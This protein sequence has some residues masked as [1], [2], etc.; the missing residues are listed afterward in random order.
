[1]GN[2]GIIVGDSNQ[3]EIKIEGGSVPLF[4]DNTGLGLFFEVSDLNAPGGQTGYS[5]IN[6]IVS[7]SLGGPNAPSLIPDED[8]Y[9][10]LGINTSRW[11]NVYANFFVGVAT[12]AQY[13]D[14]AE[15]YL[16]DKE[17]SPGTVLE[18]GGSAEV[19]L[20]QDETRRVAGIVSSNPAYLMNSDLK[21]DY[22]V[23]LALQGRVPCKV[24][25]KISKGDMLVSG[26]NGYA[27]P[28][29]DPKIGTIIGKALEDFDGTDGIIEVVVGRI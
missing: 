13:A 11:D 25:G 27:R 3:L 6:S 23:A 9:S 14:L 26:G 22:V 21:G 15:N 18:F 8:S 4:R 20:A 2:N 16:A 29:V 19:T 5:F 12:S 17:Y 28:T 1:M 24:R 10:N 7:V